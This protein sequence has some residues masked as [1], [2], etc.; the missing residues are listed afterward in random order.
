[1]LLIFVTAAVFHEPMFWLKAL[2]QLN[3]PLIFVTAAVF[4]E[5]IFWLKA[6]ALANM[7]NIFVTAAMFQLFIEG[8][9]VRE[10]QLLNAFAI[11]VVPDI[12]GRSVAV[13]VRLLAPMKY[14][15]VFPNLNGP[16]DEIVRS[17]F[18]SPVLLNCQPVIVP[19]IVMV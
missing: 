4:H 7:P 18:L 1:M 14:P 13:I 5:P 10:L 9:V 11:V 15:P 16:Q 6:L 19:L 3:M 17:L 12:S 2:V 8:T